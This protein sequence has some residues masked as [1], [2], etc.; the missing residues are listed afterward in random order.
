MFPAT[1]GFTPPDLPNL[2]KLP[3]KSPTPLK[4]DPIWTAL[5]SVS[6]RF[7]N[8]ASQAGSEPEKALTGPVVPETPPTEATQPAVEAATPDAATAAVVGPAALALKEP[9]PTSPQ[10]SNV[11]D[12]NPPTAPKKPLG[13]RVKAFLKKT[14]W[15]LFG[16]SSVLTFVA[17]VAHFNRSEPSQLVVQSESSAQLWKETQAKQTAPAGKVTTLQKMALVSYMADL[18]DKAATL[19]PGQPKAQLVTGFNL[20]DKEVA[21]VNDLVAEAQKTPDFQ[22]TLALYN[23]FA[24]SYLSQYNSKESVEESKANVAKFFADNQKELS[25]KNM[26]DSILLNAFLYGLGGVT[27]TGSLLALTRKKKPAAAF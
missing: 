24:D 11:S 2:P 18:A 1:N 7:G 13:Q 5:D 17:P 21:L 25:S 16:L 6:I 26:W 27:V 9:E 23:R 10:S 12:S 20:T 15:G 22:G 14:T 4:R 19:N 3:P 8:E